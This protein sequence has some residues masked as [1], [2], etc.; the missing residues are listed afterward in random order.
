[1][2]NLIVISNL[3]KTFTNGNN[4]M[5][6]NDISLRIPKGQ[7][8]A[9]MGPSG[10][11]KSTL[12]NLIAGLDHPSSGEIVIDDVHVEQL[13][14]KTSAQYRRHQIG[15]VY[16]FFNLLNQLTVLDNI[17]LSARLNGISRRES[18]SRAKELL[19]RL[20]IADKIHDYPSHLSGGQRQRV[21]IARAL[22]NKPSILLADEPTGAL[23]SKSGEQVMD[24]LAEVNRDGQTILMVTHD[25]RIASF[26]ANRIVTLRDGQIV[27]DTKIESHTS[28][29]SQNLIRLRGEE[30]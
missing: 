4:H 13:N 26:Y 1:M 2:S 19:K 24:I 6:I 28:L 30:D 8:T 11:G 14:E 3:K 20:G 17:V 7:F 22:I 10:S 9:I 16:Q 25:A 18:Q 29:P 12:L 15:F 5:V 23:D 27:D 21:S